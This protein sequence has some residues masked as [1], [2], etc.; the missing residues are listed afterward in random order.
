[1]HAMK[2]TMLAA[3]AALGAT[4]ACAADVTV[5]GLV[6]YGLM[7]TGTDNGSNTSHVTEMTSGKNLGSRFGFKGS[8]D[9]GNGVK[10]G[11]I[12]ENGFSADTGAL[13]SNGKIFDRE[14]TIY[15]EGNFGNLKFGRMTRLTGSTGSSCIYAGNIAPI[16]TGYGDSIPGYNAVFAGNLLRYDNV[17]MYTTP[18]FAGLKL[19]LQYSGGY[20][21][22]EDEGEVE[23]Q[24]STNRF[25]ALGMSYKNGPF[26]MAGAVE[27]FNWKSYNL[28]ADERELD[29]GLVVSAGGAYDFEVVKLFLMGV[30]FDHMPLSMGFFGDENK[31]TVGKEEFKNED[32]QGFGINTGINAPVLG[33]NL[34]LSLTYMNAEPSTQVAA[35]FEVDRCNV[36]V[37]WEDKLSKRTTLYLGAAWTQDDYQ[38]VEAT[39]YSATVGLIHSF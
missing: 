36:T 30:Y 35:D 5:Y 37:G 29:D 6:D 17:A 13:P 8:E 16:S 23:T 19:Y 9:L 38:V 15:L 32:L 22:D 34:R 24:S 7:Y 20:D 4:A 18:D 26:N 3:A 31:F 11:F 2:K 12:L 1:M 39:R 21:V 25:Y 14:S 33:G 27:R 28:T 10:V